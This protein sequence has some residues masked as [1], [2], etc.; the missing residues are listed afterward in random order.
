MVTI[1]LG[2][3]GTTARAQNADNAPV[4]GEMIVQT[5]PPRQYVFAKIETDFASMGPPIVQA[6]RGIDAAAREQKLSL[7]G[8]TMHYYY[9]APHRS[10]SEPFTMETGQFVPDDV[11]AIGKY[12]VR[13]L[14]EFKCASLLYVGTIGPS[15]GDAW[16]ALYRGVRAKGLKPTDEERELY[17]Y[18]EGVDSPNN[19]VQVQVGVE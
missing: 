16:Q 7:W 6:L 11:K 3:A 15:I 4:I 9:K 14:P 10:P 5:I 18:W 19:V 1:V 12:E 8:P 17:L 2:S 13:E